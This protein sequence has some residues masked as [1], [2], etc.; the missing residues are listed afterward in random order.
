MVNAIP[1][2]LAGTAQS[3]AIAAYQGVRGRVFVSLWAVRLAGIVGRDTDTAKDVFLV[4]D[5]FQMCRITA[6]PI[7]AK[8]IERV[9]LEQRL[10]TQCEGDTMR[11]CP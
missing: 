9:S 1:D 8:V 2:A 6:Q 10:A 11:H 3:A 4:A 5:D 7:A